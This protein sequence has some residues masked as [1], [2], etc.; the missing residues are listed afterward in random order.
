MGEIP[1]Q[2]RVV[3]SLPDADACRRVPPPMPAE[4]DAILTAIIAR[5]ARHP[6]RRGLL[7][8][9]LEASHLTRAPGEDAALEILQGH[10]I[11][12]RIAVGPHEGRKAFTLEWGRSQPVVMSNAY[13]VRR[14]TLGLNTIDLRRRVD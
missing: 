10:S 5:I 7:V 14:D 12:Y 4:L 11:A 6:E 3:K 8:R 9:D 1:G 13:P 2:S